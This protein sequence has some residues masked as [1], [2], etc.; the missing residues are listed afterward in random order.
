MFW[1]KKSI[2]NTN[3]SVFQKFPV[4]YYQEQ[5]D[6]TA[7]ITIG[8]A[9]TFRE[10]CSIFVGENAS[11][12]LDNG[13]FF[14]NYCSINCLEKIVIGQQT[15]LGEG[16]KLYDH[17]HEIN[18]KPL[19]VSKSNFKTAPIII[20]DNCW[21]GSN[22]TILKGVIIG[23]N[24]IIGANCLIYQSIPDNCIVKHSEN[25]LITQF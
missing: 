7:Q 8:N 4:K 22:V 23:N 21:I 15:M 1:K 13:T 18:K 14:N 24:V 25:L 16:V 11:L 9:V 10:F 6:K 3:Y 12:S 2:K 17:N 19:Q 20:G 5:I